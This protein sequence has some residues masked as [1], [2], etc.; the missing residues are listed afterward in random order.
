MRRILSWTHDAILGACAASVILL[1]LAL[2]RF[3]ELI[4]ELNP[5]WS[6]S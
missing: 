5:P 4:D 1:L 6:R 2:Y 3:E